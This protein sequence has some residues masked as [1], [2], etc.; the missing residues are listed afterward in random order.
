MGTYSSTFRRWSRAVAAGVICLFMFNNVPDAMQGI[1]GPKSN[2]TLAAPSRFHTTVR[3]EERYGRIVATQREEIQKSRFQ[4]RVAASYLSF[5]MEHFLTRYG[6]N[7]SADGL[8]R[9]IKESFSNIDFTGSN[10]EELYKEG[11]TFCF[12]YISENKSREGILR[13]YLAHDRPLEAMGNIP[14]P[15]VSDGEVMVISESLGE[16]SPLAKRRIRFPDFSESEKQFDRR[17]VDAGLLHKAHVK[18]DMAVKR[19]VNPDDKPLRALYGAAG[20]DVSN[21]LLSTNASEGYF[22]SFY[23]GVFRQLSEKHLKRCFQGKDPDK[24]IK[25]HLDRDRYKGKFLGGFANSATF[26]SN[27]RTIVAALAFELR[28][29]GVDLRTVQ[30][31]SDHGYPRITFRWGYKGA[32]E[33]IR[34]ITFV[35]ADVRRPEEYQDLLEGKEIDVYYQRAGNELAEEYS[36]GKDGYIYV[37]NSHLK[38]GGY[39]I[40]DDYVYSPKRKCYFDRGPLFPLRLDEIEVPGS[41][42]IG[43]ECLRLRLPWLPQSV[44]SVYYGWHV[45]I[46]QKPF[47]GG[48]P[49]SAQEKADLAAEA[50]DEEEAPSVDISRG[51]KPVQDL[52]DTADIQTYKAYD[53]RKRAPGIQAYDEKG[54]KQNVI[55]GIDTSWVPGMQESAIQGLLNKIRYLSYKKG[56]GHIVVIRQN[57]EKLAEELLEEV[58]R[59]KTPLSNVIV[60]GDQKVLDAEA[61]DLL[62]TPEA[63]ENG[64]FFAKIALPEDF[65]ENSYVRFLE[66]LT[67]AMNLAFEGPW[68]SLDTSLIDVVREGNRTF[69]FI[70]KAEPFEM[71]EL[72]EMY[73]EQKKILA[74]T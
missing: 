50:A 70:P 48:A 68:V 15:V 38:P 40:T 37:M 21:F 11:D 31:D 28:S 65:P 72:K 13:Y 57:G 63:E 46:R 1:M 66:M 12:P 44:E 45:R 20:A 55:I 59:R 67:M 35:N 43:E 73:E 34:A 69:R 52:I 51:E 56:L 30:V 4:N 23:R 5:F 26:D 74:A 64:A 14:R 47:V 53:I 3:I 9:L 60:F 7:I 17:P 19:V 41:E 25:K 24:Y 36:K 22:V 32:E 39:F 58:G 6:S 42:Q 2:H 33:Q 61:F 27:P 54:Q 10:I 49:A 62:R 18:Y 29:M 16:I 8:K 71:E